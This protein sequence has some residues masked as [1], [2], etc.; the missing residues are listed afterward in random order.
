MSDPT[1]P[2]EQRSALAQ[3]DQPVTAPYRPRTPADSAAR[4][5]FAGF[6]EKTMP[7]LVVFVLRHGADIH[8]AREAAQAA[9]AQAWERWE[10][11]E[12]P[13]AWLR[14]V[15]FRQLVRVRERPEGPLQDT[16][17]QSG[18][19]CPV[20]RIELGAQEEL[21]LKVLAGLPMQQRRAFAWIYDG[22]TPQETAEALQTT[23][24]AVRQNLAR[25]RK[26][27]KQAWESMKED[28]Q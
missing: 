26:S 24:E 18:G 14:T 8:E 5:E 16:E 15:A 28:H 27:L 9:F 19:V 7:R 12:H 22:F 20:E 3:R 4:S 13:H 10:S 25:A 1:P 21:V 23:P 2:R 11:I 6:Y 17:G